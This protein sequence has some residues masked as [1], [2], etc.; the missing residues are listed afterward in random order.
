LVGQGGAIAGCTPTI[1][2]HHAVVSAMG[3]R[4]VCFRFP[5]VDA[6]EQARRSFAHAGR[7]RE[8][9]SELADVTAALLRFVARVATTA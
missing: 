4:F 8:M 9:R 2:K 1:D 5:N 6:N 7:E 3:E